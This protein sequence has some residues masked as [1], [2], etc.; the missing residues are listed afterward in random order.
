VQPSG[1]IQGWQVRNHPNC[2]VDRWQSVSLAVIGLVREGRHI[3]LHR[4]STTADPPCVLAAYNA[5]GRT[6]SG[7]GDRERGSRLNGSGGAAVA[8][9]ARALGVSHSTPEALTSD[10]GG[11]RKSPLVDGR[12]LANHTSRRCAGRVARLPT[13]ALHYVRFGVVDEKAT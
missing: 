10:V 2:Q 4:R 6:I 1:C 9:T 7:W 8:V 13:S 5:P 3:A 11:C 12:V